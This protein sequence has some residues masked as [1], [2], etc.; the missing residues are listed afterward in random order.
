MKQC[1]KFGC[2]ADLE[3]VVDESAEANVPQ[4]VGTQL[5][6]VIVPMY[7]WLDMFAGHSRKLKNIKRYHHL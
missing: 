4:M 3:R 5:G 6:E 1:T 7:I 2:L